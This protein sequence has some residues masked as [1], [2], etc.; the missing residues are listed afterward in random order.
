[1]IF[2]RFWLANLNG[3]FEIDWCHPCLPYKGHP[4]KI[5]VK[6]KGYMKHMVTDLN[7]TN[8]PVMFSNSILG[9][10]C[11][12]TFFE[13]LEAKLSP[14]VNLDKKYELLHTNQIIEPHCTIVDDCTKV[15]C[16]T[17]IDIVS[18]ST[19]FSL[20]LTDSHINTL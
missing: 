9:N 7:N 16:N 3:Y 5:K 12:D 20:E 15:D 18:S 10:F 13:D 1:V 19:I 2:S 6:C 14:L 17:C 4:N 8:E 11:F